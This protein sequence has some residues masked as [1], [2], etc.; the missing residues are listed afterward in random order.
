VL[1]RAWCGFGSQEKVQDGAPPGPVTSQ[2]AQWLQYAKQLC[3]DQAIIPHILPHTRQ[4]LHGLTINV[5][6]HGVS[7]ADQ[8]VKLP[9]GV[10]CPS[11]E[12]SCEQHLSVPAKLEQSF[13]RVPYATPS[14]QPSRDMNMVRFTKQ[15]ELCVPG[16]GAKTVGKWFGT[17]VMTDLHMLTSILGT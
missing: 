4:A 13:S 6:Y 3:K 12:R 8:T 10:H 15:I 14:A 11:T 7:V 1:R 2:G 17:T 5:H 9:A 16:L